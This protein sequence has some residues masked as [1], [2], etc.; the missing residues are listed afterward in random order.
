M[1]WY[2]Y[3][4]NYGCNNDNNYWIWIIIIIFIIFF[5][6]RDNNGHGCSHCNR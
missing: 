1:Y 4:N 5:I 2:G 3:P 6:F